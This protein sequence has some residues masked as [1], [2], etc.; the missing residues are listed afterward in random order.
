MK[1]AYTNTHQKIRLDK[2]NLSIALLTKV[3]CK[4]KG[5]FYVIPEIRK[6]GKKQRTLGG[7]FWS[8]KKRLQN[9]KL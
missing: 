8:I 5:C 9:H 1:Y 7:K 4:V 2:I 3:K 6:K